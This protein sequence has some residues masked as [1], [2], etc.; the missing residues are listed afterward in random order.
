MST[1]KCSPRISK[2]VGTRLGY[3]EGVG[4]FRQGEGKLIDL[5]HVL[6][7]EWWNGIHVR[8]RSVCLTAWEFESPLQH[9][10]K[11]GGFLAENRKMCVLSVSRLESS[12]CLSVLGLPGPT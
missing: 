11:D 5:L 6:L 12:A 10:K 3:R 8:F 7:L 1:G 9:K 2:S 4:V